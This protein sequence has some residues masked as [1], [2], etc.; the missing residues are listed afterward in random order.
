MKNIEDDPS[1]TPGS[2]GR[3]PLSISAAKESDLF[4]GISSKTSPNDLSLNLSSS[5]WSFNNKLNNPPTTTGTSELWGGSGG[6]MSK[7]ARGPPPGLGGNG[8]NTAPVANGWGATGGST[9]PLT[10]SISASGNSN[11][12]SGNANSWGHSTWLLLKNLTTQVSEK[13][14][15]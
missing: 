15:I 14:K 4:G 9:A 3:S 8:A 11:T 6:S 10:R 7:G 5:T 2:V 13:V 12:W 1:I